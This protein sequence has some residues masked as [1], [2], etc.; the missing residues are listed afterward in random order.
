MFGIISPTSDEDLAFSGSIGKALDLNWTMDEAAT[1]TC[2][3]ESK[4][5]GLTGLSLVGSGTVQTS[6]SAAEAP[7]IDSFTWQ[8][9]VNGTGDSN[10]SMESVSVHF[11]WDEV[12]K[13]TSHGFGGY[14]DKTFH[15]MEACTFTFTAIHATQAELMQTGYAEG[16][17]V[18][19]TGT[20]GTPYA[21]RADF[22]DIWV[23]GKID[24]VEQIYDG[25][26][27][28]TVS[29]TM[30]AVDGANFAEIDLN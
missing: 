28:Q 14:A 23:R 5:A 27:K 30:I 3:M 11:A 25:I 29:C 7:S 4:S 15:G 20:A 19:L 13:A 10:L 6:G 21:A 2:E 24:S 12:K 17:T 26:Y 16:Q 8:V 9:D 22:T 18:V 1:V